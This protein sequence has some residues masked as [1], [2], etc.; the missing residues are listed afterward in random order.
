MKIEQLIAILKVM[1]EANIDHLTP[2][3]VDIH[4][5]WLNVQCEKFGYKDCHDAYKNLCQP[6]K[7]KKA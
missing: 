3:E 4:L 7:R 5:D 6:W 1:M 2:H